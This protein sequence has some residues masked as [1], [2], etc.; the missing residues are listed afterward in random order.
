MGKSIIGIRQFTILVILFTVGSSILITP[1]GLAAEAKQNAWIAAILSV[2]IGLL[3]VFL[4]QA[5]VRQFPN[6]TLVQMCETLFGIWIGKIVSLLYFC[7][8]F[9]LAALVLRNIGDFVVTQVLPDTPLQ[10]ILMIF[11]AVVIMA[12][13]QGIETIARTGEIFFPWVMIFFFAM[14]LFLA[15]QFRLIQLKPYL[16]EGIIPVIRASFPF[17]GTPFM[18]LIVLLMVIPFVNCVKKANK[19]FFVGTLIAGILLIMITLISILVLGAGITARNLYPSYSLAKMISVG[20]FLER[21]EVLMA[22]IWFITIFFKLTICFYASVLS[23]AQVIKMEEIRPLCFPFGMILIVLS[24]VTYPNES[25]FLNFVSK[26]WF[27]YA[28][29]F[30][31]L[32][33]ICMIGLSLFRKGEKYNG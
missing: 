12:S 29:T 21:L 33:P 22:G 8:F 6:Q 25:Y 13:R 5:L 24:I 20:K 10:F 30:G 19:A 4:Y 18:E 1:S 16:G 31:L 28:F 27:P 9:L 11:L 23:F 15:P 3:T 14:V 32:L 2:C 7:F 17:T 26:I